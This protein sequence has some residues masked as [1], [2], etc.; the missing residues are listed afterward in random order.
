LQLCYNIQP[1]IKQPQVYDDGT[2]QSWNGKHCYVTIQNKEE[3]YSNVT[4][5]FYERMCFPRGV[6]P[7]PLKDSPQLEW[8]EDLHKT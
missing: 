4:S 3:C 8:K 2:M 7:N 1:Q 5:K 6:N